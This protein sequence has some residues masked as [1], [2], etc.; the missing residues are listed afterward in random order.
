MSGYGGI[1]RTITRLMLISLLVP[2]MAVAASGSGCTL[3]LVATLPVEVS[4]NK[5]LTTASINGEAVTVML[6]TGSQ[7]SLVSQ[8]AQQRLHLPA[9][10]LNGKVKG[11]GGET[12]LKTVRVARFVLGETLSG[13]NVHFA[14][15][16][17][18]RYD[19]LLGEDFFSRYSV[20]FDL[21]H[22]AVRLFTE[23]HCA[24]ESLPYWATRYEQVALLESPHLANEIVFNVSV[25]HRVTRAR[26]D[27]GSYDTHIDTALAKAAGVVVVDEHV[28]EMNGI[29]TGTLA[30]ATGRVDFFQIGDEIIRNVVVNLDE[31]NKYQ[32]SV[33][34]GSRIS[35][36]DHPFD[37]VFVG[38]DFLL[39]HRVLISTE[40]KVMV[41]SFEGGPALQRLER[42]AATP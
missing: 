29:G 2:G 30:V 3:G 12:S 6:D 23:A 28:G 7:V 40:H 13:D 11:F 9:V 20:E 35:T 38:A 16:G 27:S 15:G 14:S 34:T 8:L 4:R 24:V 19:L 5:L 1:I 21:A 31:V 37:D 39:S 42:P 36:Q 25:N 33:K 22:H 41:F 10:S 32:T 18:L 26:L 17:K